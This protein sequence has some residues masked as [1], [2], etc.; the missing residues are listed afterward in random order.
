VQYLLSLYFHAG[1]TNRFIS[2]LY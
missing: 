2:P 1:S